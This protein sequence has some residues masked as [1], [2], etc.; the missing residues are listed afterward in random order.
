MIEVLSET[1]PAAAQS[2]AEAKNAI[3]GTLLQEQQNAA[4]KNWVRD[5]ESSHDV[6]YAPG[7]AP[8]PT[9]TGAG[10]ATG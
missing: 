5:A 9:G 3:S 8:A 10:T 6:T 7:Y 1:K 2:L 4:L